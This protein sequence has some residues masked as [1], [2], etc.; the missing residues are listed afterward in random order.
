MVSPP[1]NSVNT[2]LNK[3][4]RKAFYEGHKEIALF[5]ILIVFFFPLIGVYVSGLLGATL[6]MLIAVMAYFLT[7]FI[8]GKLNK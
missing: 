4:S 2:S 1:D 5:M 6:G 3:D 7:P 8:V